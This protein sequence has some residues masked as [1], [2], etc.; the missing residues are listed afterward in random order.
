MT[1][2]FDI[3]TVVPE[4]AAGYL[5]A[6]ILGRAAQ[7]GAVSF[8]VTNIRDYAQG[9]HKQV[10]DAPFGGGQGMVMKPEPVVAAIEAAL[11]NSAEGRRTRTILLDPTGVPFDQRTAER[12]AR[13]FD[14]L[15]LVCGRYEGIDD[16]VSAFVDEEISLGDFV[17]TGGELAALTVVDA[18][19]RL[20]PSVLGNELSP[21][22]ESFQGPRLE[23]PQFTRPRV[24]RDME[25]PS[26]LL[27]GDHGRIATWREEQALQRTRERRPDL[28]EE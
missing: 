2:S 8:D 20:L 19:A 23:F 12:L 11:G 24:F 22:E 16:R 25:V 26:V 3:L 15:V 7:A 1:Y 5:S 27:S 18:V 17:I 28:L 9:R 14:H 13:D 21:T 4:A 10:D 6:S